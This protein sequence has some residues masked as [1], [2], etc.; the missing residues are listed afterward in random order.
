M[1][2][3]VKRESIEE[4]LGVVRAQFVANASELL[5]LFE[6][7]AAEALF[8]RQYISL[9]V[10]VL[11]EGA[12]IIEI[13]AGAMLLSCQLVREGFKVTALEPIGTGFSHFDRM[14]EVVLEAA[15]LHACCP[16]ILANPAE[17]LSTGNQFDYGF[18]SGLV[19][20]SRRMASIGSPAQ[21]ISFLMSRILICQHFFQKT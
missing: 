14:R 10:K 20:V 7:Y 17:E 12:K 1:S 8:G 16:E 2:N 4:W 3:A 9:D 18:W 11:P 6:I 15:R 5:P 19:I 21:I 13:G